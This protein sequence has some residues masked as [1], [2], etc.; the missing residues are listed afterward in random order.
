MSASQSSLY[1]VD[2]EALTATAVTFN[3]ADFKLGQDVVIVD[4]WAWSVRGTDVYGLD[5][6]DTTQ[7]RS[8]SFDG[9]YLQ[10]GTIGG[11]MWFEE[12]DSSL[13]MEIRGTGVGVK[14]VGVGGASITT[15][16]VPFSA[17][18]TGTIDGASC[19]TTRLTVTPDGQSRVYGDPVPTYGS[20]VTGFILG[21]DATTAAGYSAPNCTSSY[22]STPPV[23]S[24]PLTISCSGGSA[25][26]YSFD[27]SATAQLTI[28]L[29]SLVNW[30]S[31]TRCRERG[32]SSGAP[33]PS[34]TRSPTGPPISSS[35]DSRSTRTTSSR[36]ASPAPLI[37]VP[38]PTSPCSSTSVPISI[39]PPDCS[40]W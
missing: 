27:T 35:T 10:S 9:S 34:P 23:A 39:R 26:D 11:A 36:S 31:A 19:R 8:Y 7:T 32:T 30:R 38:S 3:S 16:N 40:T 4:G 12:A 33:S 1:E 24:S 21:E 25:S 28:T 15:S 5:L 18:G 20:T 22:T 6:A 17:P 37:S 2:I 14:F 13:L 29:S